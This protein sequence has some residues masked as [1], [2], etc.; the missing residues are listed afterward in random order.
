MIDAFP[1]LNFVILGS[2]V[3]FMA[4]DLRK[5]RHEQS[6]SDDKA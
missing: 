5:T 1:V 3:A 4:L 2:F 6:D